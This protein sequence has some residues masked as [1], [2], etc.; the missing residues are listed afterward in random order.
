MENLWEM[1]NENKN[2]DQQYN[3]SKTARR[4]IPKSYDF[5]KSLKSDDVKILFDIGCG[6]KNDLFEQSLKSI[7]FEYHGCDPF[8][9]TYNENITSITK[10][11]DGSSDIVSIN[12]VLNT[13]KEPEIWL[14]LLCQAHNALKVGGVLVLSIYEGARLA[15]EPKNA[16]LT[17]VETRDGWQNRFKTEHYTKYVLQVFGNYSMESSGGSKI[18]TA[19]KTL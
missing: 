4:Q 18:I 9:K 12:N 6:S 8:N 16:I 14:K 5:I 2:F 15:H 11:K 13:I 7:G 17:P 10:C 1:Y 3:S 19:K